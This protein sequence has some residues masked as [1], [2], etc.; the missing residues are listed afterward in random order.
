MTRET[1]FC[2]DLKT[3]T[4]GVVH[5][6][7]QVLYLARYLLVEY[8]NLDD[9]RFPAVTKNDGVTDELLTE[10]LL[11]LEKLLSNNFTFHHLLFTILDV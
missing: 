2:N 1:V 6:Q 3:V 5:I 9:A 11:S 7:V 10:E 8:G 4:V